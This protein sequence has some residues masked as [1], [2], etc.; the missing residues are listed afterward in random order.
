M[1]ILCSWLGAAP[2]VMQAGSLPKAFCFG[3]MAAGDSNVPITCSAGTCMDRLGGY[4][5]SRHGYKPGMPVP[6]GG[7]RFVVQCVDCILL[8]MVCLVGSA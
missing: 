6:T 8:S 7:S 5:F 4:L 2:S 3:T 1:G